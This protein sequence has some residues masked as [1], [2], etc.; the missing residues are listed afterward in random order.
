MP[1]GYLV[2][3]T[4]PPAILVIGLCQRDE[5]VR[6]SSEV[7]PSSVWKPRPR[8][9][10]T[11]TKLPLSSVLPFASTGDEFGVI[12]A[13]TSVRPIQTFSRTAVH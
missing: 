5:E 2:A 3:L 8:T 10:R 7:V 13:W 9:V 1:A 12:A 11:S 4:R 6:G